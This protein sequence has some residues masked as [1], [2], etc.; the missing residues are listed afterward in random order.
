MA[1]YTYNSGTT[2][3]SV[4]V[5]VSRFDEAGQNTGDSRALSSYLLNSATLGGSSG[6]DTIVG[7]SGNDLVLWD[8]DTSY[9]NYWGSAGYGWNQPIE[10][11]S[12]GAG[13]DVVSLVNA[14][15]NTAYSANATVYGGS[16]NDAIWSNRGNDLLYGGADLDTIFGAAGNDRLFG[17]DGGDSLFG[18]SGSDTIYGGNAN[19]VIYGDGMWGGTGAADTLSGDLGDDTIYAGEG[20]DSIL[21]SAD[22][23][24]TGANSGVR[25]WDGSSNT[26]T[27][28]AGSASW[29]WSSDQ[30]FGGFA[31]SES[32]IDT[33][34]LT[35]GNDVLVLDSR[36]ILSNGAWQAAAGNRVGYIEAILAGAGADIVALNSS[37]DTRYSQVVGIAGEAGDDILYSGSG[38]DWMIGGMATSTADASNDTLAA[39]AGDDILWGDSYLDT[40]NTVGGNDT[41]FGGTGNDTMYGGA[42]HDVMYGGSTDGT[43]DGAFDT[44]FGG[45]GNDW[46]IDTSNAATVYGDAGDDTIDVTMAWGTATLFGGTGNDVFYVDGAY[47]TV[48]AYGG[49]GDDWF[50]F[51]DPSG[52]TWP[53]DVVDAGAGNDIVSMFNGN[54][55]AYGGTGTDVIWGGGG[56]DTIYG[57]DDADY[58][59]GGEGVNVLSGGNGADWYYV[60]RT[61]GATSLLDNATRQNNLVLF[62][63]FDQTGQALFVTGTGVNE[64]PLNG[65]GTDLVAGAKLGNTSGGEVDLSIAGTTATLSV[66]GGPT[67]TFSTADILTVTLWNHDAPAGQEQEIFT[68]NTTA[69][70]YVFTGYL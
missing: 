9:T 62:G 55:T 6:V 23:T 66:S 51:G 64:T 13:N 10:V 30:L 1:T 60:S 25:L 69:G 17:D 7:T 2:T 20:N 15:G 29:S 24:L 59:Y 63:E 21:F 54:D 34:Y 44:F 4:S 8:E 39:G 45:A 38:N 27:V 58:L 36:D 16:G 47:N 22:K 52:L 65:N 14:S 48:Y 57:G 3:Q 26:T 19:D 12:T 37:G 46:I 49:D 43:D 11:F 68:W 31:S 67:V 41:L 70:T 32:G 53:V 18:G 40:V 56:A 42:G 61:D 28:Y 35:A 33:L 5:T 50:S